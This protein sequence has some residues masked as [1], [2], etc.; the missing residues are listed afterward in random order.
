MSAAARVRGGAI[1]SHPTY[2]TPWNGPRMLTFGAQYRMGPRPNER[3]EQIHATAKSWE[4]SE[5]AVPLCQQQRT[6]T[7]S[8]S[9]NEPASCT[10]LTALWRSF[11]TASARR[12]P[13]RPQSRYQTSPSVERPPVNSLR[14]CSARRPLVITNA[15]R[16]SGPGTDHRQ[17]S[18]QIVHVPDTLALT[19]NGTAPPLCTTM[20][21]L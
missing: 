9:V 8:P 5:K 10:T 11:T 14:S 13:C 21:A 4:C 12:Y 17:H 18:G 6:P 16:S 20:T 7:T 19:A 1:H 15:K 3:G 2:P